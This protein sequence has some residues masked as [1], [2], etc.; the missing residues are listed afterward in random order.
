[1]TRPK[2]RKDLGELEIEMAKI[3]REI[4]NAERCLKL[5]RENGFPRLVSASRKIWPQPSSCAPSLS[6]L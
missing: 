6:R 1:M 3:D 5:A 4:A 2:I